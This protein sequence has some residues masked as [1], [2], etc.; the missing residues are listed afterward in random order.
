MK[1]MPATCA[2]TTHKR[3]IGTVTIYI[4]ANRDDAGVIREVSAKTDQGYQG[5]AAVLADMVTLALQHGAPPELVARH[6]RHH[7]Y[8]PIGV[9]GQPT[10]IA[11]AIGIVLELEIAAL[12]QQEGR[13]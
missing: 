13:Q 6:L 3:T 5:Q 7:R 12:V 9:A 11:D 10:S 8:H 4:T 1:P 2:T